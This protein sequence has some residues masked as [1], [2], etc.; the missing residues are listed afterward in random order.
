MTPL[1][2]WTSFAGG[3]MPS[4]ASAG[5]APSLEVMEAA[6]LASGTELTTVAMR[7][8]D[9]HTP[10]SVLDV[11]DRHGIA[12]LRDL[13]GVGANLQEHPGCHLVNAVSA[14]TLND[15]ARGFAGFRQLL[16]LAFARSG[17]L[18]TGIG[19]AQAFVRSREGL[20]TTNLAN[21]TVD[22]HE[23][24]ERVSVAALEGMLD[25]TLALL[26]ETT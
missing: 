21:G 5:G 18:T 14:Q 9:P 3:A 24:T 23:P 6:L 10:G 25:V 8:V 22:N 12:V 1:A 20:P 4:R 16:S 15:D 17:A 11:L 2:L 13:P 26:E 19:H 7:R